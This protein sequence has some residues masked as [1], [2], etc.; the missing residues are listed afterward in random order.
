MPNP[1]ISPTTI[2]VGPYTINN[3]KNALINLTLYEFKPR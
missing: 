1:F 3:S 2:G